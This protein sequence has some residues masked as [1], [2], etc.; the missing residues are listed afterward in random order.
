MFWLAVAV[1]F[2]ANALLSWA[3]GV[4]VLAIAQ[5]AT[6]ALAGVAGGAA[7]R[8]LREHGRHRSTAH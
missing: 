1:V 6:A 4:P 8:Q 5:V 2:A 7:A 3:F